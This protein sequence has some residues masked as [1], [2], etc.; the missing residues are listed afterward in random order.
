MEA[1]DMTTE[2]A[3]TKMMWVLGMAFERSEVEK[4]FY[5]PINFD[6]TI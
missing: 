5:T 3:L 1:Y 2:S 4:L 6:I